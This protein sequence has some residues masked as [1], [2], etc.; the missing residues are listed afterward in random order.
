MCYYKRCLLRE[1]LLYETRRGPKK[2]RGAFS[3][4]AAMELS[5]SNK[6][7]STSNEDRSINVHCREKSE[8][9]A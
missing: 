8:D 4:R 5:S 3:R 2:L 1:A 7:N 6:S 9:E